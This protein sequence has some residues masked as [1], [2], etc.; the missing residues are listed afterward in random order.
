MCERT[1]IRLGC[2]EAALRTLEDARSTGT[3]IR[4]SSAL[5]CSQYKKKV[6]SHLMYFLPSY[7]TRRRTRAYS[8]PEA[9]TNIF[10]L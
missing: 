5:V 2:Q 3:Y 4:V 6:V 8:L 1:N 10:C 7:E 9:M